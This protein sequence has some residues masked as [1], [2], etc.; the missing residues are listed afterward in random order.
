MR[1]GTVF[2][3]FIDEHQEV[4]EEDV[5]D[6][7][8]DGIDFIEALSDKGDQD[9]DRAL[10]TTRA[11]LFG[12]D[13][14][15]EAGSGEEEDLSQDSFELDEGEDAAHLVGHLRRQLKVF[16]KAYQCQVL[17]TMKI[18]KKCRSLNLEN[19]RLQAAVQMER[20]QARIAKV[21]EM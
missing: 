1:D 13:A 15:I 7:E 10:L 8:A 4:K 21:Q 5:E 17:N 19:K 11:R 3:G 9:N 16:K 18:V 12:E 20:E 6:E 14:D 2:N